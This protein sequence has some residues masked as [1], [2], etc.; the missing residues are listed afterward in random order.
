MLTPSSEKLWLVQS[1]P[2]S[3]F[4]FELVVIFLHSISKSIIP[5]WPINLTI[6]CLSILPIFRVPAAKLSINDRRD[7]LIVHYDIPRGDICVGEAASITTGVVAFGQLWA[8][9]FVAFL[10]RDIRSKV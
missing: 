7:L 8:D 2:D 3:L 4:R 9:Y 10:D 5:L 6:V 1:P